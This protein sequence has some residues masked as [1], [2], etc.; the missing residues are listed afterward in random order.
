MSEEE[1]Q[2]VEQEAVQAVD[3]ATESPNAGKQIESA[4][5]S[6]K[7][8][9]AEYN[10]AEANRLIREQQR[11]IKEREEELAKLKQRE[12]IP[13]EEEVNLNDDDI[14][15][16]AHVKKTWSKREKNL[17]EKIRK[18]VKA[19]LAQATLKLQYPDYDDVVTQEKIEEL[20]TRNPELALS[21][22]HN[23]D[24]YAQAIA[25][26]KLIKMIE[27]NETPKSSVEKE[28]ALKN[29]QKPLSVNAVPKASAVGNIGM[30]ENGL[31]PDLKKQLW[32][33]MKQAMKS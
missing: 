21:L 10:W 3:Q 15:T 32:T 14:P 16:Y 9:N 26:Y 22:S 29:S 7:R 24:P 8:N 17:E 31:T 25:A 30:F 19:E 11:Q 5:G 33:E 1:N 20:K 18:E 6:K 27:A 23:P 12:A 4:D 13:Q 28:K 2:V